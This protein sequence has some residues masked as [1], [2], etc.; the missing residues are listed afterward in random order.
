M[1]PTMNHH[2]RRLAGVGI[3]LLLTAGIAA[4][5]SDDDDDGLDTETTV[6]L[7][8]GAGSGLPGDSGD[9]ATTTTG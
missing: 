6:D 5:C 9:E 1:R 4:G 8:P 3:S 2:A 7:D